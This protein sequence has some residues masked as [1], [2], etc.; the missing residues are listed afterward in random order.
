MISSAANL[1]ASSFSRL[2]QSPYEPE[3]LK[4]NI[5][6]TLARRSYMATNEIWGRV[7]QIIG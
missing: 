4:V 7:H 5:L 2:N 3:Q 1:R 6:N